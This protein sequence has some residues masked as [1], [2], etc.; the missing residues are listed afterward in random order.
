[1]KNN[2]RNDAGYRHR[3][4]CL[5]RMPSHRK[6]RE[7]ASGRGTQPSSS[8]SKE[9]LRTLFPAK[10]PF[11]LRHRNALKEVSD[12]EIHSSSHDR[13]GSR[14]GGSDFARVLG[15]LGRDVRL[16][17]WSSRYKRCK[18]LSV[19]PRSPTGR[20]NTSYRLSARERKKTFLLASIS[21][22]RSS[23]HI[24]WK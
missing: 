9:N 21:V 12:E 23:R 6:E 3:Y 8:R 24:I 10:L 19:R 15:R 17:R 16:S 20:Q 7:P 11:L 14:R 18:S 2:L 4:Y 1:M 22:E 5:R 13:P